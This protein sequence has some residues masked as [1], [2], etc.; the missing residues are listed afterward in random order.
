M[1]VAPQPSPVAVAE[2][3]VPAYTPTP[4]NGVAG[5]EPPV[6]RRTTTWLKS[7]SDGFVQCT[8]ADEYHPVASNPV[9]AVGSR[10]GRK[11]VVT[12][13]VLVSPSVS[14]TAP[15]TIRYGVMSA[16]FAEGVNVARCVPASYETV[17]GT[18]APVFPFSS[19]TVDVLT[20]AG[21]MSRWNVTTGLTARVCVTAKSSGEI[22][23]THSC[24]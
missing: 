6:E 19:R 22:S 2:V 1:Y 15:T 14:C 12:G 9:T 17:P 21:S 8:V 20:E 13:T 24:G 10:S 11:V 5:G 3:P 7:F 23:R 4:W 18:A 16:R